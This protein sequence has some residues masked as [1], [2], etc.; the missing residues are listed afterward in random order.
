MNKKIIEYGIMG[1]YEGIA[2]TLIHK[3]TVVQDNYNFYKIKIQENEDNEENIDP[4]EAANIDPLE[5]SNIDPIEDTNNSNEKIPD[6]TIKDIDQN[7]NSEI[8]NINKLLIVSPILIIFLILIIY[9]LMPGSK[10][11]IFG[12]SRI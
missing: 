8:N 1:D 12:K 10:N 9:F 11:N 7:I 4:I 5:A 2:T 3:P 6:N